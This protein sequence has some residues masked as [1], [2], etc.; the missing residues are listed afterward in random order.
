MKIAFFCAQVIKSTKG[1]IQLILVKMRP[2]TS[3]LIYTSLDSS[4][5]IRAQNNIKN[6][7]IC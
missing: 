5:E 6:G 7:D 4:I 2:C 1:T 3:S